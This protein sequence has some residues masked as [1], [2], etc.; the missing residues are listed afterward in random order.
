MALDAPDRFRVEMWFSAGSSYN[1]IEAN[2]AKLQHVLPVRPPCP[3]HD[4]TG[5]SLEKVEALLTPFCVPHRG[6]RST[7]ARG[8]RS[9]LASR[10]VSKCSSFVRV[11]MASS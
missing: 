2:A 6:T 8:P 3:L 7:Y 4:G 10:G 1:P 9:T 5:V 11:N